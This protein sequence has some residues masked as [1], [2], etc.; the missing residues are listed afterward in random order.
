MT[1]T[2]LSFDLAVNAERFLGAALDQGAMA[3]DI[4][5]V[6]Y[7]GLLDR[8]GYAIAR[9]AT[10]GITMTTPQDA[11][12][13]AAAGAGIGLAAGIVAGMAS[14]TIPGFGLVMGG[15][16]LATAIAGAVATA[17]AGAVAGGIAGYLRDLGVEGDVREDF[18]KDYKGGRV[19][20]GITYDGDGILPETVS[21]LARKYHATRTSLDFPPA[22]DRDAVEP[23]PAWQGCANSE[24]EGEPISKQRKKPY[25]S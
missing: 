3:E 25:L 17:G 6:A 14:I 20:V 9:G 1:T 15:G 24:S 18:E 12:V 21:L 4:S 11:E 19:I 13:G 16:A 8:D 22:F 23:E 2:F 10:S 7:P 5:V